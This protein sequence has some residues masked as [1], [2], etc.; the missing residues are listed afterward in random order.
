MVKIALT[1]TLNNF[2]VNYRIY[3]YLI[4]SKKV[5]QQ[6]QQEKHKWTTRRTAAAAAAATTTATA[7]DHNACTN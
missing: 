6:Q 4:Y 3:K 1:T 7:E 2:T 5:P